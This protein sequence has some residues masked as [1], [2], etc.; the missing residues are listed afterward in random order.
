MEETKEGG[1]GFPEKAEFGASLV[2]S[3][4]GGIQLKRMVSDFSETTSQNSISRRVRRMN[5]MD[6]EDEGD[7][8][9]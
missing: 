1:F 9:K 2:A 8:A 7:A 4:G 5:I 6:D 3:D